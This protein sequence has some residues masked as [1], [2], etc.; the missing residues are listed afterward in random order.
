MNPDYFKNTLRIFHEPYHERLVQMAW[1][2][3]LKNNY[4][5]RLDEKYQIESLICEL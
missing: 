5:N 4:R 2:A 1:K 3:V